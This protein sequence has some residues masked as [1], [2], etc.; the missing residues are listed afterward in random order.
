MNN[1]KE[2]AD[3]MIE[4]LN[5][6]VNT[7]GKKEKKNVIKIEKNKIRGYSFERNIQ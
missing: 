6:V 2:E 4:D 1:A 3:E 7:I 5:C